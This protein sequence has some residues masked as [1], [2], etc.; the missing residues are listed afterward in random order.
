MIVVME[1]NATQEQIDK[2]V[3]RAK[4]LGF[5]AMINR[6]K[7]QTVVALIGD[8]TKIAN[9]DLLEELGGVKRVERIQVPF[10]LASR[11]TQYADSVIEIAPGI[12]IGG[13]EELLVMAGP[14]SVETEDGIIKTARAA[15][16]SGAKVL[17][18]GAY[19]PRTAPRTF[20]GLG[21]LGLKFLKQAK[22]ET[23][24]AVVTEIM[25]IRDLDVVLENADILQV[26]ARN[27]Q[28]FSM[29]NELGKV[30][31]PILL[32]R[33]MSA[34]MDEWLLAAERIMHHGNSKVILCERG[35]RSFDAKYTRN[36][37]DVAAVPVVKNLSHLPIIVDPSHG[38]GKTAWVKPMA[39]AS[40]AAGAHGLMIEIHP[41]PENALSDGP[42]SLKFEQFE[43]LMKEI[44]QLETVTRPL[45]FSNPVTA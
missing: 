2:V 3:N 15:K 25:D 39:L 29:L 1:P 31:R 16:A 22:Q 13:S 40:V 8:E 12:K 45:Y 10:R 17:R 41:D 28:N 35:I 43:V 20:E 42:Q 9:T 33:G 32:K 24:L 4:D 14:C 44:R 36:V 19:K 23:G 34:T 26:G 38:T 5:E 6:G 21:E 11:T 27:M 18:G 37:L 30:D 7:I